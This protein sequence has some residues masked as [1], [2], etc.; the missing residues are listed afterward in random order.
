[1]IK[2]MFN[3]G[4]MPA[5]QRLMQFTEARQSVLANNIANLSTPHFQ[6]RDLD[7]NLFKESLQKAVDARRS[8]A[9]HLG[10]SPIRGDLKMPETR[11]IRFEGD[12]LE[13]RS[14]ATNENILFH[15]RNNRDLE[16]LMQDQAENVM[17]HQFATEMLRNQYDIL[18]MA[19][20][21]RI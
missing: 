5:L 10:G 17:T 15:D 21:E 18:R 7:P 6:P 1:M 3:S 8:R 13:I 19:I 4:A 9:E 20:R 16:R 14:E 2:G 12:R 11:E